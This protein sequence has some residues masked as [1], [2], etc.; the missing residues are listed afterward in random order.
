MKLRNPKGFKFWQFARNRSDHERTGS[1]M[2]GKKIRRLIEA[3]EF[4]RKCRKWTP[5][6]ELKIR[7]LFTRR[8]DA[9]KRGSN[10]EKRATRRILYTLR[11]AGLVELRPWPPSTSE[12]LNFRRKK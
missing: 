10:A 3:W 4:I 2:V 6:S 7:L 8:T 5:S 11:T 12:L 9:A 1:E